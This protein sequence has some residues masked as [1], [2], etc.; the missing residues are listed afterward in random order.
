MK[1]REAMMEEI[2]LA[3]KNAR[4]A[5]FDDFQL[6]LDRL[7]D[8]GYYHGDEYGHDRGYDEGYERGINSERLYREKY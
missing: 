3:Y 5:L 8:L 6:M 4:P 2:L 7:Y 1:T